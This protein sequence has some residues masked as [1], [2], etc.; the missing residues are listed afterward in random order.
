MSAKRVLPISVIMLLIIPAVLPA[1][2]DT[3]VTLPEDT[4]YGIG[5]QGTFPAYGISG[6]M[7]INEEV[8][9]QAIIGFFG[10]L[11]TFAGRGLYTFRKDDFWRLYGFGM[12]GMWTYSIGSLSETVPGFGLGAGIRYDWRAFD[13]SLPP[14]FWNLELGLGFVNFDE[15]DY[16][17]S[18]IL[19]GAG[20]H[21]RF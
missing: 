10:S 17:F 9:I 8:T 19:F 4:R 2:T 21:Y 13:A 6:M 20:V 11:N 18:T 15:V 5:F 1:Q 3:D 7:D 14:L 16:N 12:A